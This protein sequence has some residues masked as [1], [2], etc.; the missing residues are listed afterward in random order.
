MRFLRRAALLGLA[1]M[2][3]PAAA[4]GQ[5]EPADAVA[6]LPWG[7]PDLQGIWFRQSSTPLERDA[8]VADKAVLSPAEAAAYLA[9]RHAAINRYLTFDLNARLAIARRAHRPP[10]VLDPTAPRGPD[11]DRRP[12]RRGGRPVSAPLMVDRHLVRPASSSSQTTT[13]R[14]R[15][16]Q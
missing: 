4:A 16:R 9:E 10:H 12:V 11:R 1:L 6:R 13:P 2:L 8:S 15:P 3:P 7:V 5:T 14:P